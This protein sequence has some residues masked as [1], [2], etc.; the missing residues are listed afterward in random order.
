MGLH[1][2]VAEI[3]DG[4]YFGTSLNRAARIMSAAHGDQVLLSAATAELVSGTSRDVVHIRAR[5]W[6]PARR[7]LVCIPRHWRHKRATA[8]R[9]SATPSSVVASPWPRWR[10]GW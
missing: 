6:R 8:Y 5:A 9:P 1:T 3:R 4:D 7:A 10:D 2:G